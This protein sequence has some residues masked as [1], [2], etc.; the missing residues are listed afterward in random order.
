MFLELKRRTNV[1]MTFI[2]VFYLNGFEKAVEFQWSESG[3]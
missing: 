3:I 1:N 2:T